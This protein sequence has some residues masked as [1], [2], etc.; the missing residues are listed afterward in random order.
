MKRE[1]S[2]DQIAR[3]ARGFMREIIDQAELQDWT[4]RCQGSGLLFF[5]P[6]SR[7]RSGFDSVH[8][9]DPGTDS[10]AQKVFKDRFR[11]AGMKFPEDQPA[12]RR[13]MATPPKF[14]IVSQTPES[15]DPFVLIR[16]K[17]DLALNLMTE[18]VDLVGRAEADNANVKAVK[19]ALRLLGQ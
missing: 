14:S 4:F 12:E 10:H 19:D 18:I 3:K 11:K 6:A 13:A 5:P 8:L 1:S 7:R 16:Q 17:V 9:S 2:V 15:G